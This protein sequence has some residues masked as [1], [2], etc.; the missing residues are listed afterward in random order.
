MD[1]LNRFTSLPGF[2][3][4]Y[5][6]L[7]IREVIPYQE[8]ILWDR[9]EGAEKSHAFENFQMAARKLAT[10]SCEGTFYGMVFQ[11]SDV[12]KWLEAAAYSLR[13]RPDAQLEKRVDEAVALIGQAQH[14]DGYLN[15]FFTV[16]EPGRRWTNLEEAHELYCAGHMIEAAVAFAEN[17]GKTGLLDV[18]RR[19]ADHMVRHFYDRGREGFPAIP[20][21]PGADAASTP[22]GEKGLFP[23]GERFLDRAVRTFSCTSGN[24]R[25]GAY[26]TWTQTNANTRRPTCLCASSATPWGTRCAPCICIP[27]WRTWRWKPATNRSRRPAARCSRASRTAGCT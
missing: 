24:G 15:T 13:I 23:A 11:D 7:V 10:G 19:M 18:M 12:A 26:G 17:T 8:A 4:R 14:P 27:A 3:N 1:T 20:V 2:M 5:E 9:V 25:P 16:K 6:D 21:R 22:D